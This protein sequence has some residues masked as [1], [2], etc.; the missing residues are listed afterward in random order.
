MTKNNS[1]SIREVYTIAQ[2]LEDKIDKI[3]TRVASIEGKA[4]VLAIFWSSIIAIVGIVIG[5]WIKKT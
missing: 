1:V 4:S 2:R 5:V 3:E